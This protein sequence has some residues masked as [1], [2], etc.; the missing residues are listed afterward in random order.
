LNQI[1]RQKFGL[2]RLNR[3]DAGMCVRSCCF[4]DCLDPS[5]E[6]Y[7]FDK[8][9]VIGFKEFVRKRHPEAVLTKSSID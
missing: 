6:N 3:H 9:D 7:T 5:V 4:V 2:V 1:Q 8:I